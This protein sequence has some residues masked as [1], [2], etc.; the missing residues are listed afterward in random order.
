M[1]EEN[2]VQEEVKPAVPPEQS[3]AMDFGGCASVFIENATFGLGML[4][5]FSK[6]VDLMSAF[7]PRTIM[8]YTGLEVVYGF[9][10]GLLVEGAMF[11]MKL[12]LPRSKNPIDWL[13]TVVVVLTPF[14]IS[15]LAQVF[16]SFE[17]RGAMGSQPEH[18][19]VA[20]AW[21]VPSIPTIII[22]LLLGKTIFSSIPPEML[23]KGFNFGKGESNLKG[24]SAPSLGGLFGAVKNLIP[25]TSA[26]A[27]PARSGVKSS[28]S[29]HA[30]ALCGECRSELQFVEY[31]TKVGKNGRP[32]KWPVYEKCGNPGCSIGRRNMKLPKAT[33]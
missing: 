15:G 33:V 11:V 26:P 9:A 23:P 19:Q 6:T 30:P 7:A 1:N 27:K 8:G 31:G 25:G 5:M 29:G 24:S 12:L 22:A 20:V 17:V 28:P 18:I 21:F 10:V 2:V 4:L 3:V 32:A 14:I 16:D 13:W